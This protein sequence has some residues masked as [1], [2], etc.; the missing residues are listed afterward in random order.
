MPTEA[1]IEA[2]RMTIASM[3]IATTMSTTMT[4]TIASTMPIATSMT[5]A[6]SLTITMIT[7]QMEADV[8]TTIPTM[9]IAV[10]WSGHGSSNHGCYDHQKE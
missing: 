9:T 7:T 10:A 6:S 8:T 2:I 4:M 5:M 3:S 1:N